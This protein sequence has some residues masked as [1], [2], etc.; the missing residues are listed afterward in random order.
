MRAATS[1][2]S[3]RENGGRGIGSGI[4]SP[5]LRRRAADSRERDRAAIRIQGLPQ[6]RSVPTFTLYVA[7]RA[8]QPLDD[9]AV[10]ALAL[11]LRPEDDERCM[12]RDGTDA[13]LL[14]VSV[15]C[16]AHDLE[17]ALDLGHDLAVEAVDLS[18]FALAVEEVAAMDEARELVWRAR[19]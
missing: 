17:A 5:L 12:W 16:S 11:V 1:G 8:G 19:L 18:S 10:D 7:L 6:T 4:R 9:D 13:A 14:R 2:G 15:D 3:R